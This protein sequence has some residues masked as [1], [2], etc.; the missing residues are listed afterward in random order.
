M[1]GA[2]ALLQ[3]VNVQEFKTDARETINAVISGEG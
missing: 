1:I 3:R 2:V